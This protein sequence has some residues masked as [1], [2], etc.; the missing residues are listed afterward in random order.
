MV[1]DETV[2]LIDSGAAVEQYVHGHE[3]A[4][5]VGKT[6]PGQRSGRCCVVRQRDRARVIELKRSTVS[7]TEGIRQ[8]WTTSDRSSFSISST[9][10]WVMSVRH[11]GLRYGTIQT[12]ENTTTWKE[13]S[14]VENLGPVTAAG[15]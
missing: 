10:Q 8:N 4:T 1:H 12:P 3:E 13:D 14:L 15:V 5:V 9:M 6:G 11:P 7:V 2:E